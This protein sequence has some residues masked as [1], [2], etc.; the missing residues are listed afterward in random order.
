MECLGD[1]DVRWELHVIKMLDVLNVAASSASQ[2]CLKTQMS[3]IVQ[4]IICSKY[5]VLKNH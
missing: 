3:D 5:C 4:L 2:R 1:N